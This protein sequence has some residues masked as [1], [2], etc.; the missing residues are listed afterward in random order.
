MTTEDET[1]HV[2]C[3]RLERLEQSNRRLRAIV[4]LTGIAAGAVLVMAQSQDISSVAAHEFVLKDDQGR[5]RA[6]LGMGQGG[7]GLRLMDERG[8]GHIAMGWDKLGPKMVWEDKDGQLT[9]GVHEEA[10]L[11]GPYLEMRSHGEMR[12]AIQADQ[13]WSALRFAD[14]GNRASQLFQGV[15][16]EG[17][18][19]TDPGPFLIMQDARAQRRFLVRGGPSQTNFEILDPQGKPVAVGQK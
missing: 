9:I 2:I 17:V 18:P 19:Q 11:P 3:R 15:L 13:S 14:Y 4:L 5:R 1:L 8:K 6:V 12:I 16:H 10:M 7:P